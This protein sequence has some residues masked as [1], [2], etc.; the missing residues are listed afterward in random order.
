MNNLLIL[1]IMTSLN[2]KD[3]LLLEG[4]F[5]TIMYQPLRHMKFLKPSDLTALGV[6]INLIWPSYRDR[7][8]I[9]LLMLNIPA[10]D[11]LRPL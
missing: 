10:C 3:R 9:L 7:H 4:N 11:K 5:K 1:N 2:V 6:F 8:I